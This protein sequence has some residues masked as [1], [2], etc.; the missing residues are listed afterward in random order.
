MCPRTTEQFDKIRQEKKSLIMDTALELFAENGY[1]ATSMSRI[2]KKAGISKGLAYNYFKSKKEILDEI[3]KVGFTTFSSNFDLNHDGILTEE[4]LVY[5]IRQS[6]SAMRANLRYWKLY[7][8][9]MLQPHV[10]ESFNE[11]YSRIVKPIMSMLYE[12]LVRKGSSD[13][14]GDM[15]ILSALFEGAG[16]MAIVAPGLFQA[17]IMEE[18]VIHSIERFINSENNSTSKS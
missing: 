13:P 15:L 9:L 14:E 11:E 5:F 6:F 1:H 10:A 7:F 2:A 17:K 12:F 16:L 4:E 18:K 8:S 3:I